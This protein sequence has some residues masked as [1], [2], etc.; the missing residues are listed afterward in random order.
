[1]RTVDLTIKGMH[2]EGCAKT[3][4][5]LLAAESGIRAATVSYA[6]SGARVL[7]DPATIDLPHLIKAVERA[8]FDVV[9]DPG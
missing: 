2:C 6:S 3:L 7:F 1:M 8:G 5:A 9:G 4:E